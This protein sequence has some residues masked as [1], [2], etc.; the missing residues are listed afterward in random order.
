M[1]TTAGICLPEGS[2]SPSRQAVV[3]TKPSSKLRVDFG[4]TFPTGGKREAL[5]EAGIPVNLDGIL[6][7]EHTPGKHTLHTN[8]LRHPFG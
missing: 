5:E 3:I 8:S 4:E 6:R 2:P 7:L 1:N